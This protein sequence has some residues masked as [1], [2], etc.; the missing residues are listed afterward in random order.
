MDA[1]KDT[2]QYHRYTSSVPGHPTI[3]STIEE[4]SE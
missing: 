3:Q 1:M 4:V 2:K